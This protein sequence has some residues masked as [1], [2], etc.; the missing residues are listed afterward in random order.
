MLIPSF[1]KIAVFAKRSTTFTQ[2][3]EKS[4]KSNTQ[5]YRYVTGI[6]CTTGEV[7]TDLAI[8]NDSIVIYDAIKENSIYDCLYTRVVVNPECKTQ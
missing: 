8:A 5:E 7:F 1:S 2:V 6:D 4:G 3:D